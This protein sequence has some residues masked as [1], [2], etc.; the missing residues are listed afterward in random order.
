MIRATG[1]EEISLTSLS[2]GDYPHLQELIEKLSEQNKGK[3][4]SLSLPSLRIDSFSKEVAEGVSQVRKTGLTFA[5]EAGTQRLR[6]IINKGVTEE[7]LMDSV[8]DAFHSG[9]SSVKLY[10]MIG[11][12]G[13]TIE[14]R[15][16]QLLVNG[17]AVAEDFF[18]QDYKRSQ[19]ANGS[20]TQD[21]GPVTLAD[22]EYFMLGDN[23]PYSSDSRW[24]GPFK[25]EQIKA[26]D[27]VVLFPF[28]QIGV[29]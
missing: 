9:Y 8:M 14:Y 29:H 20:F 22:D 24:Y 23:R 16:D 2:S 25:K 3:R 6:D 11:L 4:V 15:Q 26:K 19:S 17:E 10:F 7:N 13:E 5:P 12:P 21:F 27:V 18:D 28:Q 1:Y